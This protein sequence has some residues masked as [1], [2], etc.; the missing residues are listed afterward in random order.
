MEQ[1][2]IF[3][4]YMVVCC[5]EFR[6][7]LYKKRSYFTSMWNHFCCEGMELYR[8]LNKIVIVH[9]LGLERVYGRSSPEDRQF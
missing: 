6:I 7:V 5:L 1:N 8:V 4:I 3:V 2:I 9:V